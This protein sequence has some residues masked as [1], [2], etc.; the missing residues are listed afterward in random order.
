MGGIDD[1]PLTLPSPPQGERERN[2][3]SINNKKGRIR[4][5]SYYQQDVGH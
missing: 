4:E 3:I 2:D 1:A 5:F